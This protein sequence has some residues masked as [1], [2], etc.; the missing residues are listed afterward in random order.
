MVI[1]MQCASCGQAY[2]LKESLAGRLL[3]CRQCGATMQAPA[4][5]PSFAPPTYQAEP[6][7][8][9][10]PVIDPLARGY[11]VAQPDALHSAGYG[12]PY[13][14]NPPGAPKARRRKAK[15]PAI[16]WMA[17]GGGLLLGMA[18]VVLI[19][20]I[21]A[22]GPE[23]WIT[24][25]MAPGR[26]RSKIRPITAPAENPYARVVQQRPVSPAPPPV[27]PSPE[28]VLQ[29]LVAAGHRIRNALSA[30]HDEASA[31]RQEQE[32]VAAV[33]QFG[34]LATKLTR[35]FPTIPRDEDQRLTAIYEPQVMSVGE[36]FTREFERVARIPG[37]GRVIGNSVR[38]EAIRVQFAPA[39]PA[40]ASPRNELRRL[41]G[42]LTAPT[43][44]PPNG[45]YFAQFPERQVVEIVV[46]GL[47]ADGHE[48]VERRITAISKCRAYMHRGVNN[49]MRVTIAPVSDVRQLAAQID[50]G[51]VVVLHASQSLLVV[52]ADAAKFPPPLR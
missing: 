32:V 39:R 21:A 27:G 33:R 46:R 25:L 40:T 28:P 4:L 48:F 29:Q 43:P 38:S 7:Y 9:A 23:G 26:E 14:A 8:A 37:A 6:V 13:S 2:R 17:A 3:Q 20:V 34:D 52:Q 19:L 16:V 15:N 1:S 18:L 11:S 35:D 44:T 41:Q 12:G 47:P 51:K 24:L 45:D 36:Q 50:F 10:E 5:D 22:T 42:I 30:I 31:R 49:S